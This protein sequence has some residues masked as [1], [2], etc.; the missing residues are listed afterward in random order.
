M[1]PN[2]EERSEMSPE[3]NA[4]IDRIAENM[5][6]LS[7]NFTELSTVIKGYNG[8][9]GIAQIV[10][11]TANQIVCIGACVEELSKLPP[12]VEIIEGKV[13]T[14]ETK[15]GNTALRWFGRIGVAIISAACV[16]FFTLWINN[17]S[18]PKVEIVGS[19]SQ[20]QSTTQTSH[21]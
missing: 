20:T 15:P 19:S 18:V 17:T 14:L 5:E 11:E 2:E 10:Q 4:K 16:A 6:S 13:S 1:Y 8:F 9:K 3:E 21:R 12:K 7:R